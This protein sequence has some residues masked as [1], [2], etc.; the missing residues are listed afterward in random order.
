[1]FFRRAV[2]TG[3]SSPNVRLFLRLMICKRFADPTFRS[4]CC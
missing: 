1:M 2:N 4:W 3:F